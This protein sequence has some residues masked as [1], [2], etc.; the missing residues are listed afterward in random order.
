MRY[1]HNIRGIVARL[2]ANMRKIIGTSGTAKAH[3]LIARVNIIREEL[4][5]DI[6][7]K[8]Q[9]IIDESHRT[10]TDNKGSFWDNRFFTTK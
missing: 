4:V 5:W 7:R 1:R 2:K 8:L 10:Y 3:H 6:Q 9:Y